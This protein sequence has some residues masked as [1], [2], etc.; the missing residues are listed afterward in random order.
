MAKL[1]PKDQLP[2]EINMTN[3]VKFAE[4]LANRDGRTV[5]RRERIGLALLNPEFVRRLYHE[6]YEVKPIS[7]EKSATNDQVD[8]VIN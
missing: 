8:D 3:R 7:S 4:M 2:F 1:I 5:S 6:V